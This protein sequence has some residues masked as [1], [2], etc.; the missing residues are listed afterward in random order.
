VAQPLSIDGVR[1]PVDTTTIDT[2]LPAALDQ[3]AALVG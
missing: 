2:S 1:I 3:V